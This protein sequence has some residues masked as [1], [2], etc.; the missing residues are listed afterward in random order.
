MQLLAHSTCLTTQLLQAFVEDVELP[1]EAPAPP[2]S[3]SP[4]PVS[5]DER[6]R[7]LSREDSNRNVAGSGHARRVQANRYAEGVTALTTL[8]AFAGIFEVASKEAQDP[9]NN[10]WVNGNSLR[11]DDP[12]IHDSGH[13]Y[14]RCIPHAASANQQQCSPGN[15]LGCIAKWTTQAVMQDARTNINHSLPTCFTLST[16]CHRPPKHTVFGSRRA[17]AGC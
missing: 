1:P 3:P 5:D 9:C 13:T 15:P 16:S 17:D 8:D 14:L 6:R 11:A 12:D 2:V 4:P 10:R 7:G